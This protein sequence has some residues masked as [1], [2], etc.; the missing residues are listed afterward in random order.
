MAKQLSVFEQLTKRGGFLDCQ[1]GKGWTAPFGGY[2]WR[3]FRA[4]VALV[5][6]WYAA[7]AGNRQCIE[8]ALREV[9]LTLQPSELIPAR[10]AIYGVGHEQAM[11]ELWPVI[12]PA[13][14]VTV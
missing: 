2:G 7:D 1:L 10:L 4:Y 11:N 9:V 12:C 8:S 3:A 5:D 13:N 14:A 6:A